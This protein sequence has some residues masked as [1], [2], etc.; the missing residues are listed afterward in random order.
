M[1]SHRRR[2]QLTERDSVYLAIIMF[3]LAV[4]VTATATATAPKPVELV[5][6]V[7]PV[8]MTGHGLLPTP[9]RR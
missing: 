5:P 7:Q 2:A 6:S 1:P 4:L 3:I 8:P 9:S